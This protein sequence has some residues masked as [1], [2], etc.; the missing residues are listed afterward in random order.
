ME[1]VTEI[2]DL[3]ENSKSGKG[4]PKGKKYQIRIDREKYVVLLECMTGTAILQLAGKNPPTKYQL[5]QKM[6]GGEVKKV[7]YNEE[8]CFT[9]PGI[10][11]FMTLPLDSTEG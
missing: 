6:R 11:R 3:E 10:E 8:V 9:T 4:A 1:N 2:I 5:N 7:G